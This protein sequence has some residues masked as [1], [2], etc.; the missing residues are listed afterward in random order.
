MSYKI[1]CDLCGKE[2][3]ESYPRRRKYRF[4]EHKSVFGILEWGNIDAHDTC[5]QAV[6]SAY[7]KQKEGVNVDLH[8]DQG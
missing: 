6:I 2:I 7:R 3:E 4:Q 5:V 8:S 1:V